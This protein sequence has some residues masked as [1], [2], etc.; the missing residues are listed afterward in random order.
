MLFCWISFSYENDELKPYIEPQPDMSDQKRIEAL[1]CLGYTRNEIE[2]ALDNPNY[3]D[4]FA[5]YILLGRKSTDVSCIILLYSIKIG[6]SNIEH[7]ELFITAT[8]PQK[9]VGDY[10]DIIFTYVCY[11]FSRKAMAAEVGAHFRSVV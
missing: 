5:T 1:L 2:G 10:V 9:V 8:N 11:C 4:L 3:D 6:G 7:R